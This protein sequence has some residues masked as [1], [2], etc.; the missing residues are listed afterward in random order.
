MIDIKTM[1]NKLCMKC[2]LMKSEEGIRTYKLTLKKNLSSSNILKRLEEVTLC[3]PCD[4][5]RKTTIGK[6]IQQQ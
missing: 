6:Y 5:M 3:L 4:N 1:A 2:G